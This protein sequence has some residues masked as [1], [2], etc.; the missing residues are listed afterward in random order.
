MGILTEKTILSWEES[1]NYVQIVKDIGV[2]QFINLYHKCKN[3]KTPS[4]LWGD[5]IEYM[6]V[7]FQDEQRNARICLKCEYILSK[8]LKSKNNSKLILH[9]EFGSYMI[10]STPSSPYKGDMAYYRTVQSNMTFRRNTIRK[11]LNAN[12]TVLTITSFPRAIAKNIKQRSGHNPI[13]IPIF[14]DVKTADP[15]IEDPIIETF[16]KTDNINSCPLTIPNHLHMDSTC[17]G[18]G[19]CCL[20]VTLQA[21]DMEEAQYIYDQLAVLSPMMLALSAASPIFKGHLI[22]KDTRWE[23]ISKCCDDRTNAE[24]GNRFGKKSSTL[25]KSRY[26]SIDC[27]ISSMGSYYNDISVLND[28]KIYKRLT[29]E[30][31]NDLLAL[32]IAHL[33]DRDPLLINK[34]DIFQS[35]DDYNHFETLNSSV[36]QTVRLKPPSPPNSD[37][38]WRVEFRPIEVQLTDFE[39]AAYAIFIVLLTRVIISFKLNFLVPISKMEKNMNE[40]QKLNAVRDGNF[41]FRY[42]NIIN[43]HQHH[44]N[45]II[46]LNNVDISTKRG[47]FNSFLEDWRFMN[48]NQIFNGKGDYPGLI[49]LIHI[50]LNNMDTDY[51]TLCCINRYLELIEK[52]AS[53][54]LFTMAHWTRDFVRDHPDY[55]A[56]S[57]VSD[58]INYDLLKMCDAITK[59][60]IKCPG[61]L[62]NLI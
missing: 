16:D 57:Y 12:E 23:I 31:V 59:G 10:E 11:A 17:F 13:Y 8:N 22:D 26:D 58:L 52:R 20:Q 40:A 44:G 55:K 30:G 51:K 35:D 37:M 21:Y 38:G 41:Y 46:I 9:P 7:S 36:W 34:E 56:D 2:S 50:Y 48:L 18:I 54:K 5:E 25:R 6:L 60:Q 39:N 42:K 53:G 32:H 45:E 29:D 49:P 28:T 61:L 47:D 19:C 24:L 14:K 15:F 1:K 43:T 62:G 3:R 27:Y 4:F 33:Y